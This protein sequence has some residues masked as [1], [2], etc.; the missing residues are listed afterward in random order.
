M[1]WEQRAAAG[2]SAEKFQ[3]ALKEKLANLKHSDTAVAAS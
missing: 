3:E 2:V 1:T